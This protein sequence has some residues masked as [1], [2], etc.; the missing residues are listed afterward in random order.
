[1]PKPLLTIWTRFR[2]DQALMQRIRNISEREVKTVSAIIRDALHSH[3]ADYE[4][5]HAGDL[6]TEKDM[7]A[8]MAQAQDFA[9]AARPFK[10]NAKTTR[11]GSHK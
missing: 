1:M 9:A 8:A 2:I 3:V 4:H 11:K 6:K 7:N 10:H 5:F